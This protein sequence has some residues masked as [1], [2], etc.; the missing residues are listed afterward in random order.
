MIKVILKRDMDKY[1]NSIYVG[2]GSTPGNPYTHHKD[3]ETKA[4]F[5]VDSRDESIECFR[6]YL[7]EKIESKDEDVCLELN[8]IYLM[9]KSGDVHLACYCK[10]KSCHADVIKEIVESK[11]KKSQQNEG[12]QLNMFD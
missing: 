10:P 2:R 9:A 3:R 11:I 5:I 4:Q 8:K 6:K 1:E 7:L 12:T